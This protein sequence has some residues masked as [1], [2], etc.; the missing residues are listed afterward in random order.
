MIMLSFYW[1]CLSE[2]VQTLHKS[3]QLQHLSQLSRGEY[4]PVESRVF[5]QYKGWTH[6]KLQQ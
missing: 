4:F 6:H 3:L 1:R 5:M 2:I